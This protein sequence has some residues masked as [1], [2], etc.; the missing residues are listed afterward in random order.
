MAFRV[1]IAR[2]VPWMIVVLTGDL[3]G[4]LVAVAVLV[5]VARLVTGV[6]MVRAR[7]L[8]RHPRSPF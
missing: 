1:E 5:E 8:L 4:R 6:I 7:L 3:A 2:R